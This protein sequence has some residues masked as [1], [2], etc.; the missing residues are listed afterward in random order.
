MAFE[1]ELV[2]ARGGGKHQAGFLCV[3]SYQGFN[4]AP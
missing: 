4:D 1:L 2:Q 3:S